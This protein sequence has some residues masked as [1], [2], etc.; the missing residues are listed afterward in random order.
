M[1]KRPKRP[2]RKQ[3]LAKP[4]HTL[5]VPLRLRESNRPRRAFLRS[6]VFP[7]RKKNEENVG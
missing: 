2:S 3:T 5:E 6:L 7:T 1:C 4:V